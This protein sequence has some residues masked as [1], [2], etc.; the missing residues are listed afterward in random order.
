MVNYARRLDRVFS[1]LADPTRRDMIARLARG[2]ATVGELG[3]PFDL[4][5]G[6]VTKHVKVLERSGL[7][8]RTVVGRFHRIEMETAP[9]D[10]ADAWVS[11]VRGFWEARFDDLADHLDALQGRK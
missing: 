1:A 10:E 11:R 3:E 7:V 8:K 2:P 6:A 9:L 5:K 4:T